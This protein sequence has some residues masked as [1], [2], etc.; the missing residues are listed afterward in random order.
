MQYVYPFPSLRRPFHSSPFTLIT[1]HNK[2]GQSS[3]G[4]KKSKKTGSKCRSETGAVTLPS[5]DYKINMNFQS[6]IK[7]CLC[8]PYAH[9]NITKHLVI[10]PHRKGFLAVFKFNHQKMTLPVDLIHYKTI[11]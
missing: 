10:V 9:P 1:D 3:P 8:F 2:A 6:D 4:N 11:Q 7:W 5:K